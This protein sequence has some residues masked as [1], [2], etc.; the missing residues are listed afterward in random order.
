MLGLQLKL[1]YWTILLISKNYAVE[2]V[3]Q[4]VKCYVHR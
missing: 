1:N 4:I 2:K 3:V